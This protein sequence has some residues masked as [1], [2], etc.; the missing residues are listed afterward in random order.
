M[1]C[2]VIS[3]P[4]RIGWLYCSKASDFSLATDAIS[5]MHRP[6]Q[7]YSP[8]ETVTIPSKGEFHRSVGALTRCSHHGHPSQ[9]CT[10]R[11]R[12]FVILEQSLDPA[13]LWRKEAALLECWHKKV[14]L[15]HA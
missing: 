7:I 14:M 13:A 2:V 6:P 12:G 15:Y 9:R 1:H 3:H 10:G 4:R 11:F 8:V 5:E